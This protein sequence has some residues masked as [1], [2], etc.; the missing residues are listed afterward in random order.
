MYGRKYEGVLRSTVLIDP[1]GK[2]AHRWEKVKPAGHA[3]QVQEKLSELV[4]S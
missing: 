4:A 1:T 2:V 3:K